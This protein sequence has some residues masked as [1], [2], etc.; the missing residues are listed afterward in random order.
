MKCV[1]TIYNYYLGKTLLKK[2]LKVTDFIKVLQISS[3]C[4]VKIFLNQNCNYLILLC[5]RI[6]FNVSFLRMNVFGGSWARF[7]SPWII[8][9]SKITLNNVGKYL[10]LIYPK[11]KIYMYLF[12]E[13]VW[14]HLGVFSITLNN[15][16]KKKK[17]S[18]SSNFSIAYYVLNI[19]IFKFTFSRIVL[20]SFWACFS[21]PWETNCFDRK[22]VSSRNDFSVPRCYKFENYSLSALIP[23]ILQR[24]GAI[25]RM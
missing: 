12:L 23:Q 22:K 19:N 6:N 13:C 18:K 10:I 15:F 7:P 11:I 20:G 8:V 21:S 3:F 24:F 16:G 1:E 25:W 2:L 5:L 9:A 17:L 14:R 4:K